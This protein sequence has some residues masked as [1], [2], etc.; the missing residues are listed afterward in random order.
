[1][2]FR[3]LYTLN[4]KKFNFKKIELKTI[5]GY[6]HTGHSDDSNYKTVINGNIKARF[7]TKFLR[8]NKN[9]LR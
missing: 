8:E 9:W 3:N 7:S 6:A 5:D 1:M 4:V 2:K